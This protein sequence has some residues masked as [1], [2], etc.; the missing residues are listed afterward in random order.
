MNAKKQRRL[1]IVSNR[2]PFQLKAA[3]EKVSIGESDGGLVSALK[4][5]LDNASDQNKFDATIWIGAAD[6]SEKLWQRANVSQ[7]SNLAYQVEPIFIDKKTYNKYYNGFCNATL[8]PLF[9][10]FPSYVDFDAETFF[11]YEEVNRLFAEKILSILEPDDVLWIHDYQLMLVPGLVREHRQHATIGFFLHIPFPSFEV[12]RMLHRSWKEKI[13]HGLLG[14]DIVGFHTH[15]Y[16]QHFLKTVQMTCGYD[17]Q[18]RNVLIPGRMVKTELFPLGIDFEKF[19]S[20]ITRP[21]VAALTQSIKDNFSGKKIIFSVDRLDYTKGI[22]HRLSGFERFLDLHPEWKEKV[23]FIQVV[24]PSRQIIS[25]YTERKKLIEEE[26]GRVNGKYSTISWQPVIYRYN[27]LSFEE[28]SSMYGAADVGLITPLRDGMNLVAKEFVACK[29]GEGVLILS[30]LAGAANEMGEAIL[31]NPMDSDEVAGAILTALT[32]SPE[33]QQR[34]IECLQQRLREYTVIDWMNDFLE[35]LSEVKAIQQTQDTKSLNASTRESLKRDYQQAGKRLM[36]LDYD[37]TLVP[38]SKH[39]SLAAPDETT[40]SLLT[41]LAADERNDVTIISGRDRLF[42]SKWFGH[43]SINLIAEHGAETRQKGADWE[44]HVDIAQQWKSVI[45]PVM[46]L[47]TRR[48]PGSFIEEKRHTIVWHYRNINPELGFI[49]SRELLDSLHHMVRNSNLQIIDGNKVI[50]VRMSGIDKGVIARRF[51]D[52]ATYDF[53]MAVGDDK[54]DEDMFRAIG[55][56]GYTVKIGQGHTTAQ[57][58]L[59]SQRD[60]LKI[61]RELDELPKLIDAL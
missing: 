41:S 2:L 7:T 48:S 55:E 13:I 12:F 47:F 61:L 37:G 60:V 30:E 57:Y 53:V 59:S 50:E 43:M 26:T 40:L 27:Q 16:V 35:Q 42:L 56:R 3:G 17:Y 49:R 9:H 58:Y 29:S 39:P 31:V 8:W 38:Y 25:K 21:E 34:N 44:D 4:S 51:L 24:V 5:Y 15:E 22:T 10:Y 54:T 11:S 19:H 14:A 20:S 1:I 6:F 33:I 46:E 45:A 32:M 23:I 28:L 52:R 36:L 18:F